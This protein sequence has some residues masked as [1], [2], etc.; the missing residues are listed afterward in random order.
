Q[1]VGP[2][3]MPRYDAMLVQ[4]AKQIAELIRAAAERISQGVTAQSFLTGIQEIATV[5]YNRA[6]RTDKHYV[7]YRNGL[8]A[9]G[10]HL[11]SDQ[12]KGLVDQK[13]EREQRLLQ[14]ATLTFD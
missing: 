9:S 3:K 2:R 13:L 11:S 5:V 8:W 7:L 6:Q 4:Q 14:V 1:Y 12:W 10:V